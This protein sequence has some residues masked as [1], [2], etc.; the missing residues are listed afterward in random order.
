[1]HEVAILYSHY[2]L[3]QTINRRGHASSYKKPAQFC[4]SSSIDEAILF[5]GY[6]ELAGL[7]GGWLVIQTECAENLLLP[8]S[9]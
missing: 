2:K 3:F 1:M 4:Q 7:K 6:M 5:G 9:S 8:M